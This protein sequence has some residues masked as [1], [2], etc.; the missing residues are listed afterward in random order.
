MA[1]AKPHLIGNQYYILF[2][3]LLQ[4][5]IYHCFNQHTAQVCIHCVDTVEHNSFLICKDGRENI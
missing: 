4:F 5:G 3:D 2:R 1:F